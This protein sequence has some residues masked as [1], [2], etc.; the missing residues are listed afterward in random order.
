MNSYIII[1]FRYIIQEN[2]INSSAADCNL[3]VNNY[4]YAS[5]EYVC[6]TNIPIN[7]WLHNPFSIDNNDLISHSFNAH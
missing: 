3:L 1:Y 6:I 7:Y 2:F 4:Y 5:N